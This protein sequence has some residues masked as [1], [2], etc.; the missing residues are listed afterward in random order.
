MTLA[1]AP[2]LPSAARAADVTVSV[3]FT[4]G[5][6]LTCTEVLTSPALLDDTALLTLLDCAIARLTCYRAGYQQAKDEDAAPAS[7]SLP[8]HGWHPHHR[9]T[10]DPTIDRE[11]LECQHTDG[12]AQH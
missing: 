8:W 10:D 4:P 7:L 12:D 9:L 11:A 3:T 1:P 5:D 2:I 6:P